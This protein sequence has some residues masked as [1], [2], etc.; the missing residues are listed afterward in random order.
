MDEAEDGG[1]QGL[2]GQ[3]GLGHGGLIAPLNHPS[4]L[5]TR[6][7]RGARRRRIVALALQHIRPVDAAGA[8]ADQQLP[9]TGHRHRTLT[10]AQ[11]AGF[12][13]R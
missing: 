1:V 3:T 6:Q 11:N 12:A 10:Q 9:R 2:A 4:H 7:V 8:H 13:K 5:Q